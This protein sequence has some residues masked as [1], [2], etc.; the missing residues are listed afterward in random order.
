M[1]LIEKHL[2]QNLLHACGSHLTLQ[3]AVPKVIDSSITHAHKR[4]TIRETILC[5][6]ISPAAPMTNEVAV[7]VM[8]GWDYV[9][10]RRVV[11]TASALE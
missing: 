7:L 9:L 6:Q 11:S 1:Y 10:R 4:E 3:E 2:R 8:M 5:A